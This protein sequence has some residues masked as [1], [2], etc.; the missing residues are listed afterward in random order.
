MIAA[1]VRRRA[2]SACTSATSDARTIPLPPP[3][4]V[5]GELVEPAHHVLPVEVLEPQAAD[6]GGDVPGRPLVLRPGA[7]AHVRPA[8]DSPLHRPADGAL[9]GAAGAPSGRRRR[10]HGG[11]P[12][13]RVGPS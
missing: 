5:G 9:P 1:P 4:A 7:L 2:R 8:V 10:G 3:A 13:G 12:A 11:G 6:A